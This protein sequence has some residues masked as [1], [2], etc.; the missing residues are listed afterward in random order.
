VR[1]KLNIQPRIREHKSIASAWS[2]RIHKKFADFRPLFSGN[3]LV[4]LHEGQNRSSERSAHCEAD[5][6]YLQATPM[7][8]LALRKTSLK[9]RL[10]AELRQVPANEN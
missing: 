10:Q 7:T 5:L 9:A 2:T 3:F 8:F 4:I 6:S 1:G